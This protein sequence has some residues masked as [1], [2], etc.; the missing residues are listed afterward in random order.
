MGMVQNEKKGYITS[1]TTIDNLFVETVGLLCIHNVLQYSVIFIKFR[2]IIL[3]I[4]TDNITHCEGYFT[5]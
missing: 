5:D 1:T 4:K 2:K 3:T